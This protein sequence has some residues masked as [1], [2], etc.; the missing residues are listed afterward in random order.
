MPCGA[1]HA[2]SPLPSSPILGSKQP[3]PRSSP[4]SML[5]SFRELLVILCS[6]CSLLGSVCMNTLH[7]LSLKMAAAITGSNPSFSVNRVCMHLSHWTNLCRCCGRFLF[8]RPRYSALRRLARSSA[9]VL[10]RH[11]ASQLAGFSLELLISSR[12]RCS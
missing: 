5:A 1:M 12:P 2:L 6:L 4:Q 10:S 3:V 9:Q 7:L 8:L 11:I